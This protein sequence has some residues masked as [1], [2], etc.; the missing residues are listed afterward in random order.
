VGLRAGFR[1]PDDDRNR[2]LQYQLR[3]GVILSIFLGSW[4][5]SYFVGDWMMFERPAEL[6]KKFSTSSKELRRRE[7]ESYDNLPHLRYF[8]ARS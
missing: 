1:N 7:K 3:P 4:V 2:G 5:A 6:R 8:C